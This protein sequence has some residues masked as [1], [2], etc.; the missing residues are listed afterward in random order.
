[1]DTPKTTTGSL[2]PEFVN[3]IVRVFD[4]PDRTWPKLMLEL[5][6]VK[7]GDSKSP[8]SICQPVSWDSNRRH[9]GI[10]ISSKKLNLNDLSQ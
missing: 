8:G 4:C 10:N 3:T 5:L 9:A 7:A 1:M 2:L 6:L